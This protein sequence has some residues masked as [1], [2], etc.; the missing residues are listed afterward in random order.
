MCT[1]PVKM[2]QDFSRLAK[3]VTAGVRSSVFLDVQQDHQ[4]Q[5]EEKLPTTKPRITS[6]IFLFDKLLTELEMYAIEIATESPRPR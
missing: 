3:K 1:A 2:P 6:Y 4:P 5:K